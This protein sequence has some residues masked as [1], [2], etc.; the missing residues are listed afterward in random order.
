MQV[1]LINMPNAQIHMYLPGKRILRRRN[2]GGLSGGSQRR[3]FPTCDTIDFLQDF[4]QD[5]SSPAPRILRLLK[6]I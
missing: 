4:L 2:L 6:V 3:R 5:I 1:L